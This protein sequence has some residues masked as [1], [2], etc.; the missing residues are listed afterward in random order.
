MMLKEAIDRILSLS[1]PHI[2]M[3]NGNQYA[4][5]PLT[6]IP[7]E[8]RAEPLEVHTLSAVLDYLT[9]GADD[10]I[11]QTDIN[12]RF[13][14]HVKDYD[15]VVLTRELDGDRRREELLVAKDD[16][17]CYPFGRFLCVEDFIIGM[18]SYFVQDETVSALVKLV[19]NVTDGR[20]VQQADDGLTQSVTAKTGVVTQGKVDVPNPVLLR[21][22]CTFSEIPQPERRFVFRLRSGKEDGVLAALFAADANAWKHEATLSIRDYFANELPEELRDDVIILA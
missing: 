2:E 12:R 16:T 5:K 13:V 4:D 10:N 20:S 1:D 21:P 18:Q 15:H 14:L 8:L 17:S 3:I 7:N 9:S 19:S 11:D 6:R 22:L